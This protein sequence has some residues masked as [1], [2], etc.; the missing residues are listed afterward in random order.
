M[1]DTC[2]C[3]CHLLDHDGVA[4][5]MVVAWRCVDCGAEPDDLDGE[6]YGVIRRHVLPSGKVAYIETH[7]LDGDIGNFLDLYHR[8]KSGVS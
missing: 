6:P 1:T 5:S 3:A 8:R 7:R 4:R 2:N